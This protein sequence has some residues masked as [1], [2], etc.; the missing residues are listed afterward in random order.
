MRLPGSGCGPA[1]RA[2]LFGEQ[3]GRVLAIGPT[4][5]M[6][7]RIEARAEQRALIGFECVALPIERLSL[8]AESVHVIVSSYALHYVRD[9]DKGRLVAAAYHWLKPGGMLIVADMM[10]GRGV[11]SH[12][13]AIIR[14]KIGALAKKGI[15]GWWRIAKNGY[16]Y[17]V[18]GQ[19][20]PS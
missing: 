11:T 7:G 3:G 8:P 17:L 6:I 14:S 4:Q 19:G 12:D 13:R 10:F 18:R 2:L 9:V 5:L 15:G 16:R 1:L 20:R